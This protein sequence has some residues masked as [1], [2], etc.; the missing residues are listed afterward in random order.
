MPRFLRRFLRRLR[1]RTYRWPAEGI[2]C[3]HC[4]KR[5]RSYNRARLHF[6]RTPRDGGAACAVP[7][8]EVER[9]RGRIE[10]LE[11][12]NLRLGGVP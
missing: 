5:F 4:G 3:F 8:A 1:G 2:M 9:M 7:A 12:E 10:A 11:R 6:G